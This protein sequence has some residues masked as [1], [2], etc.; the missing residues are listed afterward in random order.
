MIEQAVDLVRIGGL[1][2]D[3]PALAPS[4]IKELDKLLDHGAYAA[5]LQSPQH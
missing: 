2:R 3:H 5:L 4:D 1:D